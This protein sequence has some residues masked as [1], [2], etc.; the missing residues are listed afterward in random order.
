MPNNC[1]ITPRMGHL[2]THNNYDMHFFFILIIWFCV[3]GFALKTLFGIN[4]V[5]WKDEGINRDRNK[6]RDEISNNPLMYE[7]SMV[8]PYLN[9]NGDT[10]Y[11]KTPLV[12]SGTYLKI[13]YIR[14][15]TKLPNSEQSSKGKVKTHQYTNR[16]NQSTTGKLGKP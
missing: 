12:K 16:Q 9:S 7:Y 2:Y 11:F 6:D 10:V 8:Q 5:N 3:V 13:Y 4:C 15:V 14:I 1:T